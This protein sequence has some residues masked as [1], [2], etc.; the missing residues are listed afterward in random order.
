MVFVYKLYDRENPEF[1]FVGYTKQNKLKDK[2][3]DHKKCWKRGNTKCYSRY[4]LNKTKKVS[5]DLIQE[6]E[7]NVQEFVL[8]TIKELKSINIENERYT[9]EYD[10]LYSKDTNWSENLDYSSEEIDDTMEQLEK[11]EN[12]YKKKLE[13]LENKVDQIEKNMCGKLE[14]IRFV[15]IDLLH[16]VYKKDYDLSAFEYI[17]QLHFKK[18]TEKHM[19]EN[20]NSSTVGNSIHKQ[21]YESLKNSIK[22][23]LEGVLY[24]FEN[25][26]DKLEEKISNL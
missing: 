6:V 14:G 7:E 23:S 2:L 17:P 20:G 19:D 24:N 11:I 3:A 25:K 26:L 1:C 13:D 9:G 21:A 18:Q 5:I 16:Q 4:I 8:S 15:M 22:L 10:N 12:D